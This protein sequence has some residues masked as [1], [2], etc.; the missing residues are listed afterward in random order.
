M[1][2]CKYQ[3]FWPKNAGARKLVVANC[4][5]SLTFSLCWRWM[6][7][8][9]STRYQGSFSSGFHSSWL[10]WTLS[11][12]TRIRG[13]VSKDWCVLYE[14]LISRSYEVRPSNSIAVSRLFPFSTPAIYT[15]VY[16]CSFPKRSLLNSQCKRRG[17]ETVCRS[18]SPK[19][20]YPLRE[21]GNFSLLKEIP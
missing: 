7:L 14:P 19:R 15:V 18:I 8:D 1:L 17:C 3:Y 10:P 6:P 11:I 12:H 2:L 9:T 5:L 20:C 16:R 21:P 13:D 4:T